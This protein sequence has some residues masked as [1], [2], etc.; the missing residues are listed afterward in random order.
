[1]LLYFGPCKG[2]IKYSSRDSCFRLVLSLA[3]A[4]RQ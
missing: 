4:C 1:M 3:P 2:V